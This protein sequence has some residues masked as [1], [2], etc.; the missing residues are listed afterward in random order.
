M[1]GFSRRSLL[2]GSGA[3]VVLAACGGDDDATTATTTPATPTDVPSGETPVLGVAFDV[4]ALLVAGVPQRAP[5]LLF[6]S[7]GG[8]MP[9]EDAPA[10]LT[11]EVEAASG[12][13][14][15]PITVARHGD[16]IGRPYWPMTT[17]FEST[18]AHVVRTTVGGARLESAINVNAP[19]AV[20]VPQLG[21]ALPVVPT[22]TTADPL[23]AATVCTQEPPCPLHE[24]S[25]DAALAEGRPVAL[26]V[27][28]PAFCQFAICGPVLELLVGAAPAHPDLA[29][30][31]LEV[32][33]GGDTR[34]E[35]VSTV[36]SE[37]LGMTYEPALFVTDTGGLVTSRLDSIYDG[38]ELDTA[39]GGAS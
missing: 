27:S 25:L 38:A 20:A 34:P 21:S 31:H 29:I 7:S 30:I 9:I 5:F 22:P 18:G 24:V 11:F 12:V 37:T 16:D 19:D 39:L 14:T 33:P 28:T 10:E 2:L 8:L 4:N 1:S 15:E 13:G 6:E 36:V 3:A 17:T 32:Y 26:L 35:S 23:G